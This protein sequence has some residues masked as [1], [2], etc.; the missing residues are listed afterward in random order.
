MKT[1]GRDANHITKNEISHV[2]N[3]AF[4]DHLQ[5]LDAEDRCKLYQLGDETSV[6]LPQPY[7]SGNILG[8]L[9]MTN[10]SSRC[11]CRLRKQFST[12]C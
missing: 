12:Y 1:D 8:S 9:C 2:F 6:C 10:I 11:F 5:T 4:D 3:D 7:G